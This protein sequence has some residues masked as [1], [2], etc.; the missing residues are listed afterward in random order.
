MSHGTTLT[1]IGTQ[2][3]LYVLIVSTSA[4]RRAW[5]RGIGLDTPDLLERREQQ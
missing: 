4:G 1:K 2:A 5:T 3:G